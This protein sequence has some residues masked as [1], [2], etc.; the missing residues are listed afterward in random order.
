MSITKILGLIIQTAQ[1]QNQARR[2]LSSRAIQG[3]GK[4]DTRVNN[5]SRTINYLTGIFYVH[6][7][8]NFHRSKIQRLG[9]T[10]LAV[11]K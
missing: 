9:K 4:Y 3:R 1:L 11:N 8:S 6:L 5:D 2:G 7:Y 10:S